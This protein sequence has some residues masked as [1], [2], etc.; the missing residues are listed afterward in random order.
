MV[1]VSEVVNLSKVSIVK[2]KE[3]EYDKVYKSVKR[4]VDLLGGIKRFVKPK[5]R[6]LI[7]PNI[8]NA[9]I[10]EKADTT[11]PLVVKAVIKIVKKIT[12]KIDVGESGASIFSNSMF[13]AFLV[14]GIK[15]VADETNVNLRNLSS[16]EFLRKKIS[17][18]HVIKAANISKAVFEADVI[19]NLPK[20]KTHNNTF[21]TGAVKNCFGFLR[22]DGR[23]QLHKIDPIGQNRF[24]QGVVDIFSIVKP[25]IKLNIM[26]AVVGMEGVGTPVG[27]PKEIGL[28]LASEDAVALDAVAAEIVGFPSSFETPLVRFAHERKIGVGDVKRIEIFGESLNSVK[29][30]DFVLP[31]AYTKGKEFKLIPEFN[32]KCIKCGECIENCPNGAI[33]KDF[34]FDREKCVCCFICQEACNYGGISTINVNKDIYDKSK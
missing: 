27:K 14:S 32:E 13:R 28:I 15:K 20:L 34:K 29:V 16:E 1:F 22:K 17:S 33:S 10:P 8:C 19:I 25:K 9:L 3:Y 4:A 26:D 30:E 6:V 7:K 12:D 2:C 24:S 11:H 5:E 31:L 21:I 18:G 23:E